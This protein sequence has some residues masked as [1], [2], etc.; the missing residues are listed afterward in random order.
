MFCLL[1]FI[2]NCIGAIVHSAECLHKNQ[3]ETS[4]LFSSFMAFDLQIWNWFH[5]SWFC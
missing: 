5:N 1:N 4:F 2:L 3:T